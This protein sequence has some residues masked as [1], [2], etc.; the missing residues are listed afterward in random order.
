VHLPAVV[1]TAVVVV[2]VVVDVGNKVQLYRGQYLNP[3]IKVLLKLIH[4]INKN[5]ANFNICFK[6]SFV[7]ITKL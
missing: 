1:V 7:F 2:V 6:F 3:G 5:R 4:K